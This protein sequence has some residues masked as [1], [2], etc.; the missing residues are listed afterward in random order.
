MGRVAPVPV[1]VVVVGVPVVDVVGGVVVVVGGV[2]VVVGGAVDVVAL[3]PP[4]ADTSKTS[5][6][7]VT[8]NTDSDPFFI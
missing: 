6:K 8:A 2:V 5:V 1:V 3:V 7:A 4:Q